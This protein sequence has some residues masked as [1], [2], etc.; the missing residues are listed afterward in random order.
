MTRRKVCLQDRTGLITCEFPET[1]AA[2]VRPG[3]GLARQNPSKVEKRTQSR[4]PNQEAI[5]N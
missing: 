1:V 5:C 3:G 2:Y 4:I